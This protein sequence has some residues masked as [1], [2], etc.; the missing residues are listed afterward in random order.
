MKGINWIAVIL[1]VV[2]VQILGFLWYGPLFGAM[3]RSLDPS[4]PAAGAMDAK[5]VGGILASLV[6]VVGMAWLYGRLGVA[7]LMDG[8]KTAL[9]LCV[10]FA[11][12]MVSMDF[13]YGGKALNLVWLNGGYELVAFLLIG[14][15]LGLLPAKGETIEAAA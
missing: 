2:L 9:I 11:L 13:F 8:L 7:N 6:L 1:A 14:A 5:M 3:W 12:T 10:A 15:C 4:A